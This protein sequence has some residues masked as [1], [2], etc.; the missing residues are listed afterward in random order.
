MEEGKAEEAESYARQALEIDVTSAA[1]RAT[2]FKALKALKKDDELA[3]LEGI[4]GAEKK[5]G[6]GK[7]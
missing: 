6:K 1:A 3:K 2:L 7:E 4:L 5:G